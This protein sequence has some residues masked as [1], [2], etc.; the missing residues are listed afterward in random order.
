MLGNVDAAAADAA[1]A[2]AAAADMVEVSVVMPC[3]NE[4][5]TLATCIRKAQ[6]AFAA[7][8]LRGEVVVADNGST[9]GSPAIARTLGARLVEV[10]ARGYGSALMGGID[11]ARGRFVVMGD[12]DDSYDFGE[13]PRFVERLRAGA[14]LVQGCRLPGGGGTVLPNA[15][16]FLHR[17]LGNPVLSFLARHWFRTPVHDVY[18]GMRGF[19]VEAYR[20][21]S[22]QCTGMEFATEML[23]KASLHHASIAEVPITLHPD[24]R[25]SH[26]PHL[27]TFRDGW[28]TLRLF[29]LFSPRWLFLLPGLALI[30]AGA[31]GYMIAL[32]GLVIGGVGFDIHT[33]LFSSLFI[34]A[35]HQAV[36]F[37][38]FTKNFA[39]REGLLPVDPRTAQFFR[40]ATLERGLLFGGAAVVAGLTLLS[41]TALTW[42]RAGFGALDYPTTLRWAIPGATLTALGLQTAFAS[43]FISVLDLRRR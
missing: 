28:R 33:L 32:P 34:L 37:A 12:A 29:L 2:G 30:A 11:A 24:G 1:A 40:H 25:T 21:L 39:I 31:A 36:F 14:D 18:C 3:L 38:L 15:M 10:V 19:S 26:R 4:A 23:I 22:L 43:F 7:A 20:R 17:W 42:W 27:R 35:G 8:G 5:D 41:A 6:D 16:P 13:I 9:D